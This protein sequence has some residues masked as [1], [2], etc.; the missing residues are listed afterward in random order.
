MLGN[1]RSQMNVLVL[2]EKQVGD[3]VTRKGDFTWDVMDTKFSAEMP[4]Q[5]QYKEGFSFSMGSWSW[6]A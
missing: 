2:Y 5:N 6:G 4:E 3:D 1:G